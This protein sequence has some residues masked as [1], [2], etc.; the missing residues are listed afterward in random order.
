ML[1]HNTN[2]QRCASSSVLASAMRTKNAFS[3]LA[4][5]KSGLWMGLGW[6]R[7]ENGVWCKYLTAYPKKPQQKLGKRERFTANLLGKGGVAYRYVKDV[8]KGQVNR[9]L[10]AH[11]GHFVCEATGTRGDDPRVSHGDGAFSGSICRKV[12]TSPHLRRACRTSGGQRFIREHLKNLSG[13]EIFTLPTVPAGRVIGRF[14]A[15]KRHNRGRFTRNR[16]P[17]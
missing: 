11:A 3:F 5:I 4:F 10:S 8:A 1:C 12:R 2:A 9:V 15:Q 17:R 14:L 16:G 13:A 7:I 6:A